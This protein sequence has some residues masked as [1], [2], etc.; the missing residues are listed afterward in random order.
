MKRSIDIIKQEFERI[1]LSTEKTLDEFTNIIMASVDA[2]LRELQNTIEEQKEEN[3]NMQ[4]QITEIRKENSE[5]Q[6]RILIGGKKTTFLL[7]SVG[8]YEQE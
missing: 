1:T 2:K 7:E 5:M 3:K 6:Q 8:T 4:G